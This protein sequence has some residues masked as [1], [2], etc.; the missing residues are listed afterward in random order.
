MSKRDN[1]YTTSSRCPICREFAYEGQPHTCS[2]TG[3]TETHTN[4]AAP[5]PDEKGSR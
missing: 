3:K 5:K 4:P 1:T 2:A